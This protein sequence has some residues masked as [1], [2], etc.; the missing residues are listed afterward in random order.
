MK[1]NQRLFVKVFFKE[2]LKTQPQI[3][4]LESMI[5]YFLMERMDIGNEV[6]F[7][8][9]QMQELADQIGSPK[10]SIQTTF[11]NLLKRQPKVIVR[12]DEYEYMIC[13]EFGIKNQDF[14]SIELLFKAHEDGNGNVIMQQ[15]LA[16]RKKGREVK[17][18]EKI[19]VYNTYVPDPSKFI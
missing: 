11:Y 10:K 19:D 4:G 15:R 7:G 9:K 18:K 5:L 17:K 8:P 12:T 2:W 1:E 6:K 3:T 14:D 13:P 16:I